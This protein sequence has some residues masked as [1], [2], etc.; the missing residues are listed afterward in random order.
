MNNFLSN[1]PYSRPRRLRKDEWIRILVQEN[2]LRT[3]NLILPIFLTYD[4]SSSEIVSMPNVY[5]NNINDAVILAKKAFDIGIKAI[6]LFPEVPKEKKDVFG[7]EALNENN[8]VCRAVREIKK[9][10]NQI[11]IICDVALDPYTLSG[12]D[13][14]YQND[15]IDNDK[16]IEILCEQALINAQSGCDIIAPSDMMDG[17]VKYIREN[18]DKALFKDTLIM[19][20]AAKYASAYYGP[21]RNAISASSDLGPNKKK[22][23]QMDYNNFNEALKEVSMDIK[24]GADI[25]LIKPG[26]PYLD[27]LSLVKKTFNFPT[28]SYQVSGEYLMINKSIESG[29]MKKEEIII[30]TLSCFKRAG[31]DAILTYFAMDVAKILS[32]S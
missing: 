31:A 9:N 30:E 11:G 32:K 8:I 28:F 1:F 26:M 22:S 23:Y 16:T 3:E 14:V 4:E 27:I 12:H 25:I 6:A 18:L 5:R 13:G 29:F 15:L 20:Y 10:V 17:R 7:K 24:E 2:V 19:S 21:F